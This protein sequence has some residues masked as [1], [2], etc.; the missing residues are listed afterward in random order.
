M[1]DVIAVQDGGPTTGIIVWWELAG[2]VVLTEML[3]A[4]ADQCLDDSWAPPPPTLDRALQRA[5]LSCCTG[6]REMLRPLSRRGRWEIVHEK[7]VH[8]QD[9]DFNEIETLEHRAVVQGWAEPDGSDNRQPHIRIVDDSAGPK[10]RQAILGKV[11]YYENLLTHDDISMWLLW[12][13]NSTQVRSVSLRQRGGF[14]FIPNASVPFWRSIAEA[15]R[16][17]SG[18]SMF[19]IPAMR[20]DEAVEAV[21]YSLQRESVAA[22]KELE[23]YLAGETSTR[24]LNS[25]ERRVELIRAKVKHYVDLL[26]VEQP[27]LTEQLDRLRGAIT[28]ARITE[29]AEQPTA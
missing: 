4:L 19:E 3:E 7:V 14:Y 12:V 11:Q 13:A 9:D 24:G 20:S 17:C 1:S 23:S 2:N 16:D 10:L 21:L 29:V 22:F 15:V 27:K 25:C 26:G 6:G 5:A 28:A 18:H 8:T